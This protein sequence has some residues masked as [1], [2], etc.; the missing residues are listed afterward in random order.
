MRRQDERHRTY[1]ESDREIRVVVDGDGGGHWFKIFTAVVQGRHWAQ[2]SA[3]AKA[4]LVVLAERVNEQQ[5][6][7]GGAWLAWPSISTIMDLAG[8]KR[9][10]TFNAI[11]EL[12]RAGLLRRR[13]PGGGATSTTYQLLE[14]QGVHSGAPGGCTSVHPT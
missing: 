9:R 7:D 11:D 1:I 8:L 13:V 3:S 10:A 12:E 14:P 4:V 5:R 2:L 6:Q